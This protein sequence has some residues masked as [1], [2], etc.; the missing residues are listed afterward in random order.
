VVNDDT[1]KAVEARKRD[2]PDRPL[3]RISS[4]FFWH[5]ESDYVMR[6]IAECVRR[7]DEVDEGADLGKGLGYEG[8]DGYP[9]MRVGEL[10]QK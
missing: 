3:V 2:F 10:V 5:L 7:K 1:L 4:T 9:E 6:P 8:G